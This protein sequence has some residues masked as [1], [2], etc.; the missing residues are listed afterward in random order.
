MPTYIL[1]SRLTDDGCKTIKDNAERIK[2]VNKDVEEMGGRVVSQYALLGDYDFLNV[3]EAPD[4]ETIQKISLEL[5]SRGTIRI[6]TMPAVEADQFIN[7]M[8]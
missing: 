8:K 4:N 1:L 2:E 3:V 7:K 5:A 6:K